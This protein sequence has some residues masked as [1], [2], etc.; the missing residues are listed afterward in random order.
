[1][2]VVATGGRDARFVALA[3]AH[4]GIL[5][6][7][8]SIPVIAVGLWWNANTIAHN[9]IHRPFFRTMAANRAFSAF[10]SLVLGIPQA[11]WRQRHLQHHA[12]TLDGRVRP[13]ASR[14]PS[15]SNRCWCW[16]CGASSRWS[17]DGCS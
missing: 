1:M 16:R 15:S 8:P 7:V 6:A 3:V 9:F 12:E 5:L 10:L 14:A 17:I 13:S 4:A 2:A 11:L